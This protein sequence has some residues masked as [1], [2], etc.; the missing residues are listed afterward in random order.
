MPTFKSNVTL[1][2]QENHCHPVDEDCNPELEYQGKE[3][4]V[5]DLRDLDTR[6]PL[7]TANNLLEKI[8]DKSVP[9]DHEQ[10]L[11]HDHMLY[12]HGSLV[13]QSKLVFFIMEKTS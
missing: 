6:V 12:D 3:T 13:S 8:K 10:A 11:L 9:V 5:P 4:N 1:F 7:E 2:I